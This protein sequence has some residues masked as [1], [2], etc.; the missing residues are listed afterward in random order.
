MMLMLIENVFQTPT[1]LFLDDMSL[2]IWNVQVQK[3]CFRWFNGS[4]TKRETY[5]SYDVHK[6]YNHKLLHNFNAKTH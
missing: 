4:T 5:I 1:F 2:I 6:K 3:N